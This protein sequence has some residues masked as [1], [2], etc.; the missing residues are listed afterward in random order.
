MSLYSSDLLTLKEA[1]RYLGVNPGYIMSHAR[2][3]QDLKPL[4]TSR[5]TTYFLVR[6]LDR[7]ARYVEEDE[8]VGGIL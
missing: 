6:E 8:L 7:L 3:E 4:R 5:S 2:I 1:A